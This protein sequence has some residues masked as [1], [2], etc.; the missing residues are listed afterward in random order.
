M[1]IHL[2]RSLRKS[3]KRGH[4]WVYKDAIELKKPLKSKTEFVLLKDNKGLVSLGIYDST[5]PIAFRALDFN[6]LKTNELEQELMR[7]FKKRSSLKDTKTDGYRL[8][9][10]EGDGFSGLICD[11]YNQVAVLQF[12]GEGMEDFWRKTEVSKLLLKNFE[13]LKT[14][15]IKP[16][17]GVGDLETVCGEELKDFDVLFCESGLKF[18]ANLL[19]GQKTGFF[20]DQRD[21]R[22]YIK[23]F[24]KDKSLLNAFSYT[25]G[26]S[27]YAG[28]AEANKVFSLDLSPGAVSDAKDNWLLNDLDPE[29][30]ETLCEDAFD[31]FEKSDSKFDSVIV[32]PPSMSSSQKTKSKAVQK[33]I[34]LFSKASKRVNKQGDLVLS[35]CSSQITFEDFNDI[36]TE[37]LSSAQKNGKVLRVSGQGLDH[38]YP[39][40][41]PELR[42][43]KFVHIV[44][45]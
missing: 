15:L 27:V 41:C 6:P 36:I 42:Y 24:A 9:N 39:H 25:G 19:K 45:D 20:F 40:F 3:I 11:V 34:D 14:V 43:L 10:G 38:P 7:A 32:D 44:L 37:A 13:N 31:F 23:S 8:I 4:P 30:H 28:A 5:S 33:Y 1:D 16:R 12:D 22:N 26:F 18:K 17:G 21:N 35:S 2:K 29:K